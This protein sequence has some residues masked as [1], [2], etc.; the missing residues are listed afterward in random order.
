MSL[1][2]L[3][4]GLTA[5]GAATVGVMALPS[6]ANALSVG[7]GYSIAG[8]GTFTDTSIDFSSDSAFVID[9]FGGFSGISLPSTVRVNDISMGTNLNQLLVD[10]DDDAFDFTARSASF[11]GANPLGG[12]V[13]V[14]S[15]FFGSSSNNT[16]SG[17]GELSQVTIRQGAGNVYSA[18]F[19]VD[20][21]PTPALLPGLIGMG[22][23]ALR[24]RK[25]EGQ[26]SEA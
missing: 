22:V 10:F 11:A 12:R 6:A 24:K 1:K 14:F 8:S 3:F 21:V 15:G 19:E 4:L 23:A 16:G 18:T 20:R 25:F 26:E 7:S 13:Y 9:A 17:N 2:S 5:V